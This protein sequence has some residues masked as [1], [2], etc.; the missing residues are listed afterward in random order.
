MSKDVKVLS[1]IRNNIRYWS[2]IFLV[3]IYALSH[4]MPRDK[5]IWVMGSTF[6]R[7]FADNPKYFY[8]YLNQYHKDDVRAI[9]ISKNKSIVNLLNNNSLEAYY[10]Y[11][12]KG[13]WFALRAK[14]YLYDNYS[15][16]ICFTLSGGAI[17]INLWHGIP[18]KKIQK[19]N[20]FDRVRNPRNKLEKVKWALRRMSD[21]KPSDYVL[22]TS[23]FIKPIFSSAFNTKNVLIANY[24]RNDYIASDIIKNIMTTSEEEAL[25]DLNLR[26]QNSNIKVILYMPTFRESEVDFFK[27]VDLNRLNNYLKNNN[28]LFC[29]KL[30]TKSKLTED[31]NRIN[32]DNIKVIPSKADPYIFL[33]KADVLVTDYSSIY[34]DFLLLDR[35]IVFFNYDIDK[36]LMNSRELYFDYDNFTP[37]FKVKDMDQLEEALDKALKIKDKTDNEYVLMRNKI[38]NTF[39]DYSDNSG[40]L[41]LYNHINA[42]LANI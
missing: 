30:H 10:L 23:E 3:P 26:T 8:L 22:A 4:L 27:V 19:D 20:L 35:P 6:G 34:F 13:I 11:S 7:R 28:F 42:L 38:K 29:I 40:S 12:L 14:V 39:F 21:E 41:D 5:H 9:W 31:F 37:G 33:K 18:L 25:N 1:T 2:Q 16:D 15:K 17:K 24:P 36:Y 32:H